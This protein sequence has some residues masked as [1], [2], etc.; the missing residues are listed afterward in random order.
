MIMSEHAQTRVKVIDI[1]D[2]YDKLLF[3][4]L[5][6]EA[7]TL[8]P[9]PYGST[10]SQK[11]Y[12]TPKMAMAATRREV[13][14]DIAD[15]FTRLNDVRRDAQRAGDHGL[16]DAITRK[17][18]LEIL[19]LEY[20][21]Q[22]AARDYLGRANELPIE[23]K[24]MEELMRW[25][26]DSERPGS[27]LSKLPPGMLHELRRWEEKRDLDR[28]R[29]TVRAA[30]PAADGPDPEPR[31][32]PPRAPAPETGPRDDRTS[33]R[34]DRSDRTIRSIAAQ[35]GVKI[36]AG[37]VDPRAG[38]VVY[39]FPEDGRLT[40]QPSG[41][42]AVKAST[43]P[44]IARVQFDATMRA[45][46]EH[47]NSVRFP[48]KLSAR[49]GA[50]AY[51]SARRAGLNVLGYSPSPE[52]E[53]QSRHERNVDEIVARANAYAAPAFAAAKARVEGRSAAIAPEIRDAVAERLVAKR[54]TPEPTP[55]PEAL[56][57]A[58]S[59]K[60]SLA[61]PAT[62]DEYRQ[63]LR[64]TKSPVKAAMV[65]NRNLVARGGPSAETPAGLRA[66]SPG[67]AL[68]ARIDHLSAAVVRAAHVIRDQALTKMR[69]LSVSARVGQAQ[70]RPT[71][72]PVRTR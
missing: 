7:P 2:L 12:E 13:A 65:T 16:A 52:L 10:I 4:N 53:A 25:R 40:L 36:P 5:N 28:V 1:R 33:D 51:L 21:G 68:S 41:S 42:I 27:R 32:E 15:R 48:P 56:K 17:E 44:R 19:A 24:Y 3:D 43:D 6:A 29:E 63:A 37:R 60:A 47:G 69:Q 59:V 67:L 61:A 11:I 54:V 72:P 22:A 46:S 66:L 8:A 23:K 55:R 39:E 49:T 57:A 31:P 64:D 62:H 26:D 30:A 9:T 70:T 38:G 71:P 20:S 50:L 34:R 45:L 58:P 35:A 18:R 14:E